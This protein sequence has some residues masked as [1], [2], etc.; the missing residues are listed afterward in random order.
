MSI[1]NTMDDYGVIITHTEKAMGQY[2]RKEAST[3]GDSPVAFRLSYLCSGLDLSGNAAAVT[4][5]V[6]RV[7]AVRFVAL[8]KE[9]Q[10]QQFKR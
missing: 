5:R 8:A 3:R 7:I 4:R 9:G 1:L 2:G 10:I 6:R